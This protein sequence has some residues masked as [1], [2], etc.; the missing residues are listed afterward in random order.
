MNITVGNDQWEVIS[1]KN[2]PEIKSLVE[3][4][5]A[6]RWVTNGRDSAVCYDEKNRKIYVSCPMQVVRENSL[7]LSYALGHALGHMVHK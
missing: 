2:A 1:S 5:F 4:G 6:F 7:S 3:S